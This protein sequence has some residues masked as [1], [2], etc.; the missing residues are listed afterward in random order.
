MQEPSVANAPKDDFA[1]LLEDYVDVVRP[2][3]GELLHGTVIDVRSDGVLV[4]LGLKREGLVPLSDLERAGK[5][6]DAYSA[7][8]DIEV[9]VTV[10]GH[11]AK[12][13]ILSVYQA[14]QHQAW[15]DVEALMGSGEIFTGAVESCNRGG[16]VVSYHGLP[17]FVPASHLVGVTR[18]MPESE[19]MNKL[20]QAVG[21]EITVRVIEVDRQRH[22]LVFSQRAAQRASRE[23]KKE[24]LLAELHEGQVL[25]G[26]VS[27]VREFG[28]FVDLGAADGLVHVSEIA[29]KQIEHP[30]NAVQPGDEVDVMV[31]RI[32]RKRQRIGLSM[33]QLLPSP[34][35]SVMDWIVPGETIVGH[36]M[37]VLHFGAF[38]DLG[39]GIEGL[40]HN[41]EIPSEGGAEIV[42]G[43]E[44]TLRVVSVDVERQRVGLSLQNLADEQEQRDDAKAALISET[45]EEADEIEPE[46]ILNIDETVDQL[47]E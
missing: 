32:D 4:D 35:D 29:W 11:G 24:Q 34:W 39:N 8:E 23:K 16:V 28:A 37:R 36:V 10:Q 31:I 30:R 2:E 20:E 25:R 42:P 46:D 43:C 22:R 38:V 5:R 45:P 7:G 18:G 40:L 6:L 3:H 19:R 12:H 47:P 33:K 14:R 9:L 44:L 1:T 27:S 17:G 21:Q 13:P 26:T 15:R 41:T